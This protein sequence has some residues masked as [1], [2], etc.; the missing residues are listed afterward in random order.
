MFKKFVRVL[1]VVVIFAMLFS[2]ISFAISDKKPELT[3]SQK[4]M[5]R[6]QI[7][8]QKDFYKTI[9]TVEKHVKRN[10][11]G[12]LE[13]KGTPKVKKEYLDTI[14]TNMAEINKLIKEGVLETDNNLRV[15]SNENY[16]QKGNLRN[17][18]DNYVDYD[19]FFE[20]IEKAERTLDINIGNKTVS[21]GINGN[22]VYAD[23]YSPPVGLYA[24][25]WGWELAL[26]EYATQIL[27][28]GLNAGAG[29]SA[30][31]AACSAAG[32][33]TAG[34]AVPAAIISAVLWFDGGYIDL[35]DYIGGNKGVYFR[36]YF[37]V[38]TPY[39]WYR[40]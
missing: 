28:K 12:T 33:I 18:K 5:I 21:V 38:T 23:S 29:A 11:D 24:Y 10:G 7:Q 25:W 31:V 19:V 8:N 39:I 16:I 15:Y 2:N 20:D 35:I 26:D 3:P 27:V 1:T 4:Q 37:Y 17:N 34:A 13:I 40:S 14:K 22:A 32:I 36:S 9:K 6:E 30:I